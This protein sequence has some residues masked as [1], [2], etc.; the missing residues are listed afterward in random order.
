MS[1]VT[2]SHDNEPAD[3]TE[4]L[5]NRLRDFS[6]RQDENFGVTQSEI[7]YAGTMVGTIE[8]DTHHFYDLTAR[9]GGAS[10]NRAVH[11]AGM[12]FS[13]ELSHYT[14]TRLAPTEVVDYVGDNISRGFV[15]LSMLSQDV[16]QK[17]RSADE[18]LL[19]HS[20]HYGVSTFS[21]VTRYWQRLTLDLSTG[22]DAFRAID[23]V[24]DGNCRQYDTISMVS[25]RRRLR[26]TREQRAA[27]RDIRQA[28]ARDHIIHI[29]ERLGWKDGLDLPER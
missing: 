20:S 11:M 27:I 12:G 5:F 19:F 4:V 18:A 3:L 15:R 22:T 29:L 9:A 28:H 10:D 14:T 25:H 7:T 17:I 16:L 1:E 23:D 26:H 21:A 6:L 2:T 8:D 13:F 24:W